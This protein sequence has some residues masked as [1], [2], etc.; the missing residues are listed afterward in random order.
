[1]MCKGGRH[2]LKKDSIKAAEFATTAQT[3]SR[4]IYS[5]LRLLNFTLSPK[6]TDN[7]EAKMRRFRLREVSRRRR[8]SA[9]NNVDHP[10]NDL[11]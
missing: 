6:L 5:F 7:N 1:M 4:T 2:E 9:S 3:T 8:Y 11:V 10:F